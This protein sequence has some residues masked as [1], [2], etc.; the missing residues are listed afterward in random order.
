MLRALSRLSVAGD[1]ATADALVA[2]RPFDLI[3]LAPGRR[4]EFSAAAVS[5]LLARRPLTPAIHLV[6]A[7][8]EGEPRSGAVLPGVR[9]LPAQVIATLNRALAAA[10]RGASPFGALP[11]TATS[12]DQ[13]LAECRSRRRSTTSMPAAVAVLASHRDVAELLGDCLGRNG[14]AVL[15]VDSASAMHSAHGLAA[16]IFETDTLDGP[17][18]DELSLFIGAVRPAPVV[19]LAGFARPEHRQAA[20]ARGAGDVLLKPFGIR[21]LLWRLDGWARGHSPRRR[22]DCHLPTGLRAQ[23]L[24]R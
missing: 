18:C 21:D 3:V 9:R 7:W 8:L 19:V 15:A 4:D 5:A 11:A 2:A 22:H 14:Y 24:N 10:R 16:G 6:A 12:D 1:L 23:R 17:T 20:L 13:I